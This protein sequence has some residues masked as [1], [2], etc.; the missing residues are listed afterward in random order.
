MH[1]YLLFLILCC[2]VVSSCSKDAPVFASSPTE[3]A[4]TA[5]N[6]LRQ[7]LIAA[8]YGWRVLYFPNTDSLLY[9][10][11]EQEISQS[12]LRGSYG[13]GGHCFTMSFREDN[14]V[15]MRA[16]FSAATAQTPLVS[17]YS[18]NR[19]SF[20]QLSFTT[21]SYVHQL[22]NERFAGSSDWLFMGNDPDGALLFRTAQHLLPAREYIRMVPLTSAD[23]AREVMAQSVENRE[24]FEAMINPQLRIHRGGRTFF[25][26]D[27]YVKRRVSTNESLLR[28]ITDKRFYLFVYASK[29]N[30]I[31]D[32]PPRAIT[33]L[34]SGYVGTEQGL[35]FRAGL[36]YSKDIMFFDFERKGN[37]FEAE[38]VEVYDTLLRSTRRVS[39]HLHPEGRITGIKAEIWDAQ[40]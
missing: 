17:E 24:L 10:N 2:S 39:R 16:D 27:Y 3:R 31:P 36:R 28:E 37:R 22:V 19:N 34:G 7:Q 13:Y 25:Q 15:E 1:K 30:P 4:Q 35:T 40:P 9:S 12:L 38:L 5:V 21:Y 32:Y 14:T 6:E 26:S 23:A 18:I 33:G 11:P 20:A 29:R 8:P